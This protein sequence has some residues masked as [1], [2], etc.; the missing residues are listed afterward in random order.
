MMVQIPCSLAFINVFIGKSNAVSDVIWLRKITLV[1]EVTPAQTASVNC[2]SLS[3][4]L[5]SSD[6]LTLHRFLQ[7]NPHV[8][9]KAPY[10]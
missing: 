7:I 4:A 2:S 8:F 9:F 6:E 10:S 3:K 1:L 5:G